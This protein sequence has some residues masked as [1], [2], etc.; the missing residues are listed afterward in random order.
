[1]SNWAVCSK[2]DCCNKV[3]SEEVKKQCGPV[4]Q[5]HVVQKHSGP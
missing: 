5:G 4:A 3:K 2:P 1:M